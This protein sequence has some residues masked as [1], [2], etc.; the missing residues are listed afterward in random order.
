MPPRTLR[1]AAFVGR[2]QMRSYSPS[3][4]ERVP[5]T[6]QDLLMRFGMDKFQARK[7]GKTLGDI[8]ALTPVGTLTAAADQYRGI[9]ADL[10]AGRTPSSFGG[11]EVALAMLPGGAAA[12]KGGKLAMDKASRMARAAEMGLETVAPMRFPPPTQAPDTSQYLERF[13][14]RLSAT[15]GVI[16]DGAWLVEGASNLWPKGFHNAMRQAWKAGKEK[17]ALPEWADRPTDWG[18]DINQDAA[19]G[20]SD[21]LREAYRQGRTGGAMPKIALADRYGDTKNYAFSRNYRDDF[22]ERGTSVIGTYGPDGSFN[23]EW[24]ALDE[25]FMTGTKRRVM[26]YLNEGKRGSDGEPLLL[27]AVDLGKRRVRSKNAAFDPT[28]RNSAN[29]LASGAGAA[30][31]LP[32]LSS[33]TAQN[34]GER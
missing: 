31:G 33:M 3:M 21:A 19:L 9:D 20:L 34:E 12:K 26:G 7:T 15:D 17:A 22:S 23:N 1:D 2:D 11:G 8:L 16:S 4:A 13:N 27:A 28:K 18:A 32:A 25:A 24:T 5:Q 6:L 10:R 29:L 14:P 30:F